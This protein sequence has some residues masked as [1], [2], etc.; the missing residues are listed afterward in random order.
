ML[1]TV[2]RVDVGGPAH[3]AVAVVGAAVGAGV[4]VLGGVEADLPGVAA[5]RGPVLIPA[6]RVMME[7]ALIS[8]CGK[9]MFIHLRSSIRTQSQ[10]SLYQ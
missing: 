7:A 10:Q 1:I 9:R 4:I 5:D 8:V 3:P 6:M 2:R